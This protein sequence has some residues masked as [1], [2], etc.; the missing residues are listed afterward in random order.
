M[1]TLRE[2]VTR[3]DAET[4]IDLSENFVPLNMSAIGPPH[5]ARNSAQ[6]ADATGKSPL[7]DLRNTNERKLIQPDLSVKL[8]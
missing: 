2:L 7:E 5:P 6:H 4:P 3:G 8:V 1:G